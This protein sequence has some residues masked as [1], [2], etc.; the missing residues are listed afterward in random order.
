MYFGGGKTNTV[1]GKLL[2]K[3]LFSHPCFRFFILSRL[4]CIHTILTPYL[5]RF[6]H[7]YEVLLLSAL[8]I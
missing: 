3:I 8:Q 6:R 5:A 4:T 1:D 2:K 7:P